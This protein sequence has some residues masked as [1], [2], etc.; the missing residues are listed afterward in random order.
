MGTCV[1]GPNRV[2]RWCSA[3]QQDVGDQGNEGALSA[4]RRDSGDGGA[5]LGSGMSSHLRKSSCFRS[6][7]FSRCRLSVTRYT[8]LRGHK[9]AVMSD[10]TR[11]G[12]TRA[13]SGDEVRPW[14][15]YPGW[16]SAGEQGL[17]QGLIPGISESSQA[18][19]WKANLSPFYKHGSQDR[20]TNSP[21]TTQG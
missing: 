12:T 3:A 5:L 11:W 10:R 2:E 18:P 7:D 15:W 1:N 6:P 9:R 13:R 14:R 21:K 4:D 19:I 8:S 16:S 17:V 20:F